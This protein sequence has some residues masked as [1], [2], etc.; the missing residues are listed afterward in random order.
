MSVADRK[1]LDVLAE[2]TVE[3]SS[4]DELFPITAALR[5][6][7]TNGW[8]AAETGPQTVRLLFRRPQQLRRIRVHVVDRVSER[9]Q[10]LRVLAGNSSG[11]LKE[12][13]SWQFVFSP[14]S[15]TEEVEECAVALDGV[16][17]VELYINPD[18]R[19]TQGQEEMYSV[20]KS[21]WLSSEG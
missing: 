8:R 18:L 21:F 2:A 7:L 5:H 13:A 20:L 17:V 16:A 11:T 12:I 14:R 10:Q 19:H 6:D 3:V 1:W 9:T 15:S 4:E